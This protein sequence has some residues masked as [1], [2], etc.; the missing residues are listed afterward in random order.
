MYRPTELFIG[1]RYLRA[2][3][4]NRY[5]SLFSFVSILGIALG[6]WLLIIILSVMNGFEKEVRDRILN[7]ISHITVSGYNGKLTDWKEVVKQVEQ[8]PEVTGTAPYI[9]AE[10]MLIYNNQVNGALFRGIDPEMEK[11]I[12]R[13]GEHMVSGKLSNLKPGE[14]GIILGQDLAFRLGVDVGEKVTMVTPSA[15]IT[16]AGVVPRLKRFTVIGLFKVGFHEYDSALGLIHLQDAQRVFR[17]K[18]YVSGVQVQVKNLFEVASV[19]QKLSETSLSDYWIKDWSYYHQNWFSAVKMEKRMMSVILFVIIL[20]VSINIVSSL[21]MIVTDKRSD[22]AILRTFGASTG[23]I[24]RIF[25]VQGSVVG[26]IGTFTGVITGVITAL[27]L[28]AIYQWIEKTLSMELIDGSVYLIS[29]LPSDLH[30]D[31]VI[32]IGSIS[33]VMSMLATSFPAW[34]ASRTQP[35][36]ALRYE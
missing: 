6:V 29:D 12:S 31:Q 18:G 15:N 26:V 24:M 13:V 9:R 34:T 20:V 2:E 14:F 8:H 4:R 1:L 5:V 19:R 36:D 35:A 21:I 7:M 10:G 27:N 25:L 33:L 28:E 23:S 16:P 30:W 11:T 17:L 22:I 32:L 3:R